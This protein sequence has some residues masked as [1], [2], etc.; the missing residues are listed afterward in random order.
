MPRLHV[1]VL[2]LSGLLASGG[3][4]AE[5]IRMGE[6]WACIFDQEEDKHHT[7]V[8]AGR[9][10]LDE[11]QS[12]LFNGKVVKE[13][14]RIPIIHLSEEAIV[15]VRAWPVSTFVGATVVAIDRRT[16]HATLGQV[17][18]SDKTSGGTAGGTCTLKQ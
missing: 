18:A 4:L 15:A 3:A 2:A 5:P 13:S 11:D 14:I 6:R 8:V 17:I 1:A 9:D 7:Y 16:G 10:L 12:V